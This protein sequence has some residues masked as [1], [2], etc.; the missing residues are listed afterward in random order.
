[1]KDACLSVSACPVTLII[2]SRIMEPA[3]SQGSISMLPQ[4]AV[5]T[6]K[7]PTAL[8]APRMDRLAMI[9]KKPTTSMRRPCNAS[10]VEL[11]AKPAWMRSI[12]LV[13]LS[14]TTS[15][16]KLSPV[17]AVLLFVLFAIFTLVVYS[18]SSDTISITGTHIPA[19]NVLQTVIFAPK[20]GVISVA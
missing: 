4:A 14:H 11:I 5:L 13:A 15:S 16:T 9:V 1:M 2:Y 3:V 7:Q 12:V 17:V 18:A 20:K 10:N 6:V 19:K 8:P